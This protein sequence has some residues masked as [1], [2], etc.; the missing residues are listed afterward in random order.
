L[1]DD[2]F[3][4]PVIVAEVWAL[5]E[6]F[7]YRRG[8][9]IFE[10]SRSVLMLACAYPRPVRPPRAVID[11]DGHGTFSTGAEES[12]IFRHSDPR[13]DLWFVRGLERAARREPDQR[14]DWEA[15][16]LAACRWFRRARLSDWPSETL[17]AAMTA[18]ECL[19]VKSKGPKGSVIAARIGA[20]WVFAEFSREQMK[21]WIKD[22]YQRRNDAVHEGMNYL[23]D[24]EVDRLIALVDH[25]VRWAAWHLDD[26]HDHLEGY[27]ACQTR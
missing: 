24:F 25:A 7:A 1:Y 21:K 2:R 3:K 5:E 10:E 13:D 20:D 22:L 11:V 9:D 26:D 12:F 23:E 18:L 15:R 17:A 6:E 16:A 19:F 27:R 14:T 4:G 8:R